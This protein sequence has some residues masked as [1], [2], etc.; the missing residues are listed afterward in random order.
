MKIGD[1]I[2]FR[3]HMLL[4]ENDWQL[5]QAEAWKAGSWAFQEVSTA[6]FIRPWYR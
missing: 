5:A 2:V 3:G 1:H 6:L 4:I